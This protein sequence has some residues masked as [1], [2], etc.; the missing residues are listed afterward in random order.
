MQA[1][2]ARRTISGQTGDDVPI[3]DGAKR[4]GLV[5]GFKPTGLTLSGARPTIAISLRKA[6]YG[7]GVTFIKGQSGNPA[8]GKPGMPHKVTREV[9]RLAGKAGPAIVRSIIEKARAGDP[10][11]ASL[12]IR[13]LLPKSKLNP[14]PVEIA[15]PATAEEAVERIAEITKKIA[16]GTLDI[17]TA[18]AL[19]QGLQAFI[20]AHSTIQLEG[21]VQALRGEVARLTQRVEQGRPP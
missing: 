21:E 1:S 3:G 18:Q 8:G 11:Y 20:S 2:T 17:D 9:H 5:H 7:S 19:L 16:A 4:R 15:K 12:F 10:F 14:E 6:R 13:Y